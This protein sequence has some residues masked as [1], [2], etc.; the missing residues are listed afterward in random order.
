MA[1]G[2]QHH[3]TGPGKA[4]AVQKVTNPIAGFGEIYP[5]AGRRGLEEQ[6]VIRVFSADAQGVVVAVKYAGLSLHPV[7][8]HRQEGLPRHNTGQVMSQGLIHSD[9][10][11]GPWRQLTLHQVGAQD[12]KYN[13]LCH[14]ISAFFLFFLAL[15]KLRAIYRAPLRFCR[16]DPPLYS[17]GPSPLRSALF[18]PC[19]S[20]LCI[21]PLSF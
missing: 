14:A 11:G 19:S 12:L 8:A 9:G 7:G 6:V 18:I 20:I 17:G 2:A 13:I 16:A 15:F 21:H 1:V 3:L 4:L 10:D 5:K